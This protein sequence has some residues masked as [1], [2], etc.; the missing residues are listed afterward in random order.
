M[1]PEDFNQIARVELS[2]IE[3]ERNGTVSISLSGNCMAPVVRDHDF[4]TIEKVPYAD[5]QFCDVAIFQTTPG[6]FHANTQFRTLKDAEKRC[7]PLNYVGRIARVKRNGSEIDL[8]KRSGVYRFFQ[9][10]F[11]AAN[12]YGLGLPRHLLRKFRKHS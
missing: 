3:L 9:A 5:L 12:P 7:P 11:S 8:N 1:I 6:T 4:V 2:L 10:V